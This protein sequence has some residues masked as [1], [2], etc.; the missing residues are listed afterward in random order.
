MIQLGLVHSPKL[1]EK[2]EL[3]DLK[4][5]E[6]CP[7]WSE[8]LQRGLARRDRNVLATDD[9]N[10]I[11]GEAWGFSG[12]QTG[13]FFAPLIPVVGCWSCIKFGRKIGKVAEKNEDGCT[14]SDFEPL[15]SEFLAHWNQMHKSI[16]KRTK[17]GRS[18]LSFILDAIATT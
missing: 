6:V 3:E 14:A 17:H 18:R 7:I 8:K 1:A 12:K 16:A 11:V 9:M 10:C 2:S 13:Y 4:L 5:E 15:I